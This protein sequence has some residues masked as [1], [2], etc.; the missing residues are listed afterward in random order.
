MAFKH[1][2]QFFENWGF[3]FSPSEPV[4]SRKTFHCNYS[5]RIFGGFVSRRF[6]T[7]TFS[8]VYRFFIIWKKNI[9]WDFWL[10]L[11]L[12]FLLQASPTGFSIGLPLFCHQQ[13]EDHQPTPTTQLAL[14]SFQPAN[15][16]THTHKAMG[17]KTRASPTSR[18]ITLFLYIPL[19]LFMKNIRTNTHAHKQSTPVNKRDSN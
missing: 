10:D 17:Y 1:F 14:P 16:H 12:E 2:A 5:C 9:D 15:T 18:R 19:H 3:V 11:S 6:C 7:L 4:K 8:N 13:H